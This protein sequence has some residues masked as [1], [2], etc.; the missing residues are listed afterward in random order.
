MT[1]IIIADDESI[2]R[3]GLFNLINWQQEGFEVVGMATDGAE[4]LSII[5]MTNADIL[6][7]DIKMPI[8]D[9]LELIREARNQ[10]P[11]LICIIISGFDEF[12][13]AQKSIEVGAFAYLLKPVI[14][15][16]LLNLLLKA[17]DEIQKNM[18]YSSYLKISSKSLSK[19][20]IKK[21]HIKENKIIK[22][23][24]SYVRENFS[25]PD[26]SLFSMSRITGYES[27]YFSK[28][29]KQVNETSFIEF[30]IDLRIEKAKLLLSSGLYSAKEVCGM[31]GYENYPYFSSLFKKKTGKSPNNYRI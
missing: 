3:N 26:I 15:E 16:E 1:K 31:V 30:L 24:T 9:G 22:Q 27:T 5:E 8:L 25:N 21:E 12:K 23:A 19:K 7:T 18:A 10:K 13:Y 28:L 11:N 6:I 29:F 20:N 4:A 14:K 17:K 2:I